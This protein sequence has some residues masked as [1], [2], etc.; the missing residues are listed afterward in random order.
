MRELRNHGGSAWLHCRRRSR[1]FETC[2]ADGDRVEYALT[3]EA[4]CGVVTAHVNVDTM[5]RSFEDVVSEARAF[6][7][8]V[9]A[10]AKGYARS[11]HLV[12]SS[13]PSTLV[14]S[15][16]ARADLRLWSA[17]YFDTPEKKKCRRPR[18]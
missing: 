8:A 1:S 11:R 5:E 13:T 17:R 16:A 14:G 7:L 9:G 15:E 10:W 12:P 3:T 2:L 4:R 18:P 6:R